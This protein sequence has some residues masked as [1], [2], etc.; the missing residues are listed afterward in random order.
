MLLGHSQGG[1]DTLFADIGGGWNTA[2]VVG[3]A[4][5]MIDDAKG[6][7]D[8]IV[9]DAHGTVYTTVSAFGDVAGD[10]SGNAQ[11]GHDEITGSIAWRGGA[12]LFAGDAGGS[13][14]TPRT[15]AT[16]RSMSAC[17]PRTAW[18]PSVATPSA[19]CAALRKAAMTI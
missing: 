17:S 6:G 18:R 1:N 11:G 14:M 4:K 10:M 19:P 5:S 3:D 16:T 12:N 2:L 8:T 9:A 7:N 15:A 13:M